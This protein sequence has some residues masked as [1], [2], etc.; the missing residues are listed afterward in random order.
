M[1]G[2]RYEP[3]TRS[4]TNLDH[5]GAIVTDKGL[6]VLAVSHLVNDSAASHR[7]KH[8]KKN[9]IVVRRCFTT[10]DA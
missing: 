3:I 9:T 8:K 4:S 7:F 2:N 5:A 6:D 10:K 1:P